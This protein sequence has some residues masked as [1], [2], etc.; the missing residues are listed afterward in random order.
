MENFHGKLKKFFMG[1]KIKV[2]QIIK[3][4]DIGGDSGGAELFGIKLAQA[5]KQRGDCEVMIC[6]FYSVHTRVEQKWFEEL[7]DKGIKT[8][9]VSEWAGYNHPHRYYR[10]LRKL[11]SIIKKEQIDVAHSHFQQG[12]L[13]AVILKR[14]GY[15]RKAF[16][17][18]HI[19][20]EWDK[21]KWTWLLS[22]LFM[23]RIFP[24]YLDGEVGVSQAVC[25]HLT[26]R[27]G[28]KVEKS[29]THLIFNGIDISQVLEKSMVPLD[30]ETQALLPADR[31]IIG[32]VGRLTE[33]K[34]YPF[35]L[36]AMA[37]V[38]KS[39]P[40]CLLAIAGDGELR[41]ELEKQTQDL[42]ISDHV[43]F[44]G[45]CNDI[46]A[47]MRQWDIFVLSSLWE[48]LPTVILEAMACD[49]PVIATDIPGTNE[50]VEDK[51]TG[52]LVPQKDPEALAEAILSLLRYPQL[53]DDL[54]KNARKQLEQYDIKT[55]AEQYWNLYQ[56][57]M[58]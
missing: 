49:L 39:R 54:V 20:H 30:T 46:P 41:P 29:K 56:K 23:D 16:R 9:F 24:N 34:G 10:G 35:I 19:C 48:G 7:N 50:L 17:T 47:L 11:I 51:H 52:L 36:Q 43:K 55:I 15:S 38:I 18:A 27:R 26:S 3:G 45:L 22:P 58:E 12:S 32:C 31:L 13:T 1:S 25:D 44:L 8:F 2:L 28:G 21:G 37:A 4:L 6:A 5:L 53:R 40:D 57:T 42:G 14:F 33:Q